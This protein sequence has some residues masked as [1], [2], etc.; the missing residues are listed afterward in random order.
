MNWDDV[1][2]LIGASLFSVFSAGALVI[3][4]ASWLGK[5]WAERILRNETHKLQEQLAQTQSS[6]NNSLE[7]SKRELDFLK[8]SRSNI[9]NDKIAIYRKIIDMV[10][11][12]L[13]NLDLHHCRQ[14]PAHRGRTPIRPV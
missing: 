13:A 12:L 3:G 9:H 7:R 10:A 4:L 6:L 8:E 14:T 1:F 11:K 5:L 2:R